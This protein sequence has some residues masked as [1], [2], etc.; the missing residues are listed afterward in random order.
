MG[1]SHVY[2]GRWKQ[3]LGRQLLAARPS[4]PGGLGGH[5]NTAPI[6]SALS[7]AEPGLRLVGYLRRASRTQ[8][9]RPAK[10]HQDVGIQGASRRGASLPDP[11]A[12]FDTLKWPHREPFR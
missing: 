11:P 12:G 9:L 1:R 8:S 7:G 10:R 4:L 3:R 2:F 5:W 6:G